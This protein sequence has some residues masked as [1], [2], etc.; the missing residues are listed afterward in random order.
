MSFKIAIKAEG[1]SKCDQICSQPNDPVEQMFY[2]RLQQ[3]VG[4][5]GK[6]Y[7]RKLCGQKGCLICN[8]RAQDLVDDRV[9]LSPAAVSV[10]AESA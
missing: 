2:T 1:L 6:Q 3:L 7:G 5:A 10:W 8:E 9:I 4:K